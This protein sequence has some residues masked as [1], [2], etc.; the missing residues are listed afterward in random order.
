MKTL[1]IFYSY[2]GHTKRLAEELAAKESADAAEIRDRRRPGKLKAYSLGCLAAM[3]GRPWP[4]E[5]PEADL[6]AYDR[7]ILL[8]P[9]W[10]GNPPPAVHAFL[11]QLPE[12]KIISVKMVSASGKSD[13]RDRLEAAVKAKGC[14]LEGVEDIKA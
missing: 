6:P 7:L 12:G 4:I 2:T 8:S 5:Q 13:C 3:R 14:T 10:A 11:E 9:V 1:V